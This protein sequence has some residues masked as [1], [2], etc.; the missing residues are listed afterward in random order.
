M[1]CV[2]VDQH[3][4]TWSRKGPELRRQPCLKK[5]GRFT[6][7]HVLVCAFY[8]AV[9]ARRAGLAS[10]EAYFEISTCPLKLKS[11]VGAQDI[12]A[13][14]TAVVAERSRRVDCAAWGNTV[15]L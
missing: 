7:V 13:T 1:A 4:V 5:T 3:A 8:D 15:I 14:N 2:G 6:Y 10:L 12:D 9:V 11:T